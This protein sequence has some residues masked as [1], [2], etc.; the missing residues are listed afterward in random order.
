M[1]GFLLLGNFIDIDWCQPLLFAGYFICLRRGPSSFLRWLSLGMLSPFVDYYFDKFRLM[2]RCFRRSLDDIFHFD[3]SFLSSSSFS[4][5]F[6]L[7]RYR[8]F[9]LFVFSPPVWFSSLLFRAIFICRCRFRLFLRCCVVFFV[10]RGAWCGASRFS[11]CR[12][13]LCQL[14]FRLCRYWFFFDFFSREM[15]LRRFLIIDV[16]SAADAAAADVPAVW[17]V[18]SFEITPLRGKIDFD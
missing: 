5:A 13:S 10:G 8:F 17:C 4:V 15:A 1:P 11:P 7:R 3:W 18:A 9:L 14:R 12:F 6:L 2:S 16:L